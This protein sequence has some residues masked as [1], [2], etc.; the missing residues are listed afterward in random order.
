MWAIIRQSR[1]TEEEF[2]AAHHA[3]ASCRRLL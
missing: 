3:A 1:M 2:K